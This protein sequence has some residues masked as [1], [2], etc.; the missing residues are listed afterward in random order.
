[1]TLSFQFVTQK[2]Q[3]TLFDESIGL[4]CR[5]QLYLMRSNHTS[6]AIVRQYYSP[7]KMDF[8]RGLIPLQP[9]LTTLWNRDLKRKQYLH[10]PQR[11]HST[12]VCILNS[13]SQTEGEKKCR[14]TTIV[15]R[16]NTNENCRKD[17]TR[18]CRNNQNRPPAKLHTYKKGRNL[19]APIANFSS[20]ASTQMAENGCQRHKRCCGREWQQ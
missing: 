20:N 18:Q 11:Q 4:T 3:N 14:S 9:A 13:R 2:K 8:R 7:Y 17:S 10:G 12:Q 5:T 15:R 19:S 16:Q 6:S 1:M